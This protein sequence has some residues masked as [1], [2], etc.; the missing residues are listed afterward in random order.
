MTRALSRVDTSTDSRKPPARPPTQAKSAKSA[1]QV[2]QAGQGWHHRETQIRQQ[3]ERKSRDP[4]V[5]GHICSAWL[6]WAPNASSALHLYTERALLSA[7]GPITRVRARMYGDP[8][9]ILNPLLTSPSHICR[10]CALIQC[11]PIM[12]AATAT[13]LPGPSVSISAFYKT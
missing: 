10:V 5:E 6:Q 2:M 9:G 4:K 11:I 12:C 1:F 8:S 3:Q 13:T 7:Y